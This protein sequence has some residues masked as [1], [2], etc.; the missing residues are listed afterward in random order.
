MTRRG[1]LLSGLA[2]IAVAGWLACPVAAAAQTIKVGAVVP[3]RSGG[4]SSWRE[5]SPPGPTSSCSTSS[6]PG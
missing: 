3:H 4:D 5:H 1:W 2:G 6:W